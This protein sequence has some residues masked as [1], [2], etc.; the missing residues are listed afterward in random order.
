MTN[1]QG[2][3]KTA[4]G[5]TGVR[6][7][8]PQLLQ[9]GGEKENRT[10]GKADLYVTCHGGVGDGGRAPAHEK[11]GRERREGDQRARGGEDEGAD[12]LGGTGLKGKGQSPDQRRQQKTEASAKLL[13]HDSSSSVVA[14]I[15]GFSEGDNSDSKSERSC[16]RPVP[17]S[18]E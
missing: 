14:A 9:N 6:V 15:S 8:Q 7:H 1:V 16:S 3:D 2:R 12:V 11:K 5:G 4:F 18:E 13:V 10:Q 17:S